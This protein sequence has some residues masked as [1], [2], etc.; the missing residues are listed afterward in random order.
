[1]LLAFV[2]YYL[3]YKLKMQLHDFMPSLIIGLVMFSAVLMVGYLQVNRWLLLILQ[4][5]TGV[6][7]YLGCSLL[8]KLESFCY[9]LKLIKRK[10]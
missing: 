6:I 9:V 2:N 1:M 8:F 5:L 7:V 3:G 10:I 4:I